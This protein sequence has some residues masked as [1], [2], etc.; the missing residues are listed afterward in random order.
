MKIIKLFFF[1]HIYH[2]VRP[3]MSQK[4]TT[5]N[6]PNFKNGNFQLKKRPIF[7]PILFLDQNIRLVE[8]TFFSVLLKVLIPKNSNFTFYNNVYGACSTKKFKPQNLGSQQS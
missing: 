2:I 7:V 5:L 4:I 6:M 3:F 1:V 8:K